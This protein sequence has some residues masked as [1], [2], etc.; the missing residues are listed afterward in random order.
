MISCMVFLRWVL[1]GNILQHFFWRYIDQN[2][3]IDK[4]WEYLFLIRVFLKLFR[5][6]R[7]SVLFV[8][9]GY[10]DSLAAQLVSV[11]WTLPILSLLLQRVPQLSF[12]LG[13]QS[14]HEAKT[15]LTLC[16]ASSSRHRGVWEIRTIKNQSWGLWCLKVLM[17]FR[18]RLGL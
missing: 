1:H 17:Y 12:K 7:E 13:Y 4:A 11:C 10:E 14:S 5:I 3:I 6:P 8:W 15:W 2:L 9:L 16:R 18:I